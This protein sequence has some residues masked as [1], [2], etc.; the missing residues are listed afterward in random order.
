MRDD[1]AFVEET[2]DGEDYDEDCN[3]EPNSRCECGEEEEVVL[4][5][6]GVIDVNDDSKNV[7]DEGGEEVDA[8][9]RWSFEPTGGANLA[10]AVR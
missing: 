3:G 10:V 1:V 2:K 6:G 4:A 8:G 9:A 5:C 7:H